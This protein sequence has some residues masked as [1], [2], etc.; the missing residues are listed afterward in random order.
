MSVRNTKR[1]KFLMSL[2][3]GLAIG[4][5]AVVY[6]AW[7]LLCDH[8]MSMREVQHMNVVE[9]S[10]THPLMLKVTFQ[11]M[12]SALVTR[13]VTTRRHGQSMTILYHLALSGLVKPSQDW[14]EPYLLT[15]PDSVNEV[16][17]GRDSWVIWHRRM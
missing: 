14:A 1:A 13:T 8:I 3:I 2:L 5:G 16:R 17:F 10:G 4:T 7:S 11:T 9:V 15:V 6:A 12:D